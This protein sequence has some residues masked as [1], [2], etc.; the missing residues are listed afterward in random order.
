MMSGITKMSGHSSE[1]HPR[2]ACGTAV[3]LLGCSGH[4]GLAPA[5]DGGCWG[6]P[7]AQVASNRWFPRGIEKPSNITAE[8]FASNWPE[9]TPADDLA[10]A[11][12][13]PEL[14][15]RGTGRHGAEPR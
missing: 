12:L 2:P 13:E 10:R 3:V 4:P 11:P 5:A 6:D 15:H 8:S 9:I 14:N 1:P 7:Y